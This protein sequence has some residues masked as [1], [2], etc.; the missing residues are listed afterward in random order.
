MRTA[1]LIPICLFLTLFS[2]DVEKPIEKFIISK[3]ASPEEGG[4]I[5][6]SPE[7]IDAFN[8]GETVAV[9]GT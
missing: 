5:Y 8:K 6:F 9:T 1:K 7:G 3:M 4:E 2:C